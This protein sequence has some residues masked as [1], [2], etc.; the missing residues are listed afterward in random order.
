V[1]LAVRV[2]VADRGVDAAFD[3]PLGSTL[4][5]LGPNGAG[6]STVLEAIAGLVRPSAGHARWRGV[7]LYDFDAGRAT[8]MPPRERGVSLVTQADA[9]F[10]SMTA[11]ANVAFGPRCRGA[12]R[13]DAAEL[14][15]RWL[16][17]VGAEE[18][19]DRLP[20]EL[21]GGQSRRVSIARALAAGPRVLLLDEP[22]ASLDV[23]SATSIRG[24]IADLVSSVTAIIT[25]H[26]ALDAHALADSVA[27][28]DEGHVV[29]H[30]DTIDVLKRP[31]T[32]FAARM[33]ARVLVTGI[34]RGG[35]LIT[36][37]GVTLPLARSEAREGT[38][39]AV[40][41]RPAD[42]AVGT[43]DDHR[44]SSRAWVRDTVRA[45]EPHAD[46]VRI[47]GTGIMADVDAEVAAMIRAGDVVVFGLPL[48]AEAYELSGRFP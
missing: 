8:W 20:H 30:G 3:L 28:M 23:D 2:A 33:G 43:T 16:A 47:H 44:A 19:A 36:D 48:D 35:D 5:L 38:R 26:D 6:K 39:A 4:A 34:I 42:V 15:R 14:A 1:T 18:L 9:L 41:I 24:L 29:E 31:R 37:D 21:S 11:L 40:A 13:Y 22:F 10:P 7:S 45:I 25:T 27:I 46:A 32:A 12:S 17:R